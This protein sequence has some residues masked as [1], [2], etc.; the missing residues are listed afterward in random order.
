MLV[1]CKLKKQTTSD[2]SESNSKSKHIS[3]SNQL[4]FTFYF[5]DGCR[6]RMKGNLEVAERLFKECLALDP[7]SAAVKYELGSLYRHIGMFDDALKYAKECA[8]LNSQNE[9]YQILYIDC[10]NN[11]RQYAQAADVYNRLIKNFPY[12][13]EFYQGL[14]EQYVYLGNIEKAFKTFDEMENKFGKSEMVI[15]NKIKLLQQTNKNEEAEIELKKLIENYPQEIR[16]Y[17]F[18]AEFYQNTNQLE[19]AFSIYQTALQKEPNNPMI[20]LALADYY[21]LKNDQ[22]SFFNEIKIAFS[23]QDLETETKAKILASYYELSENDSTMKAQAFQLFDI[24]LHTSPDAS[25]IHGLKGDFYYRDNQLQEAHIEYQ[26]AIKIDKS[27]FEIWRQLML[28]ESELGEHKLLDENTTEAMEL[29]PNQPLPYFFNGLANSALKNYSKAI[30]SLN[31]GVEFV[32][33]NNALLLSFFTTLGDCYNANKDYANSDKAFDDA[34]KINP[35]NAMVLNNYAYYLSLRK[36]HLDKA[37]KFSRRSNELKP[38]NVNFIDTY[39]WILFQ[40]AKYNEAEQWLSRAVKL[41]NKGSIAEHY[42]D[43]L[44]KLGKVD[45]A[46]NYWKI[47]K[48]S[49]ISTDELIKK[50]NTKTLNE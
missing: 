48:E 29:F 43:V 4:K 38:N 12:R 8:T 44:F 26:K 47:A 33:G 24:A 2:H 37:E 3:E 11:K 27:N 10:L 28:V 14:A 20:H 17:T 40:Q 7:N 35:D 19:K 50:I 5:I 16:Y 13:I 42:G 49:G 32:Y 22:V 41:S 18:L 34:L 1:S 23:S 39:G 46:L 25:E 31:N 9:W 21:K 30:E 36:E 6:E 45:E 15:L